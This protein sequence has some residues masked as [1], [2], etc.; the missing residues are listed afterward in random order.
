M[1]GRGRN[2]TD[3][4]IQDTAQH[5]LDRACT[6]ES[7]NVQGVQERGWEGRDAHSDARVCETRSLARLCLS[8]EMRDIC[9]G[10][11]DGED[12]WIGRACA[13]GKGNRWRGVACCM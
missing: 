4:G 12:A 1:S 5:V 8:F 3:G 13:D 11:G 9:L 10:E 7:S 2:A 6:H